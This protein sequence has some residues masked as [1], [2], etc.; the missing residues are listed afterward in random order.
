MAHVIDH[1]HNRNPLLAFG[2]LRIGHFET[3]P[4]GAFS[5]PQDPGQTPADHRHGWSVLTVE[6]IEIPALQKWNSHGSEVGRADL[7][8][9]CEMRSDAGL[10]PVLHSKRHAG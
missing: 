2:K 9:P 8:K 7:K 3:F 10:G 4:N 5:G 6:L 1:A